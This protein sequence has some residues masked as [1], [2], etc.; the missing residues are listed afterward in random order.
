MTLG[1]GLIPQ[2]Q[3]ALGNDITLA[4]QDSVPNANIDDYWLNTNAR[5]NGFNLSFKYFDEQTSQ[6][7]PQKYTVSKTA[8]IT[9]SQ[10]QVWVQ[11]FDD[12]F[13]FV[14]KVYDSVERT[15]E[16]LKAD[17]SNTPP[18]RLNKAYFVID[19][20]IVDFS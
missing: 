14:I 4:I 10:D 19:S 18:D 13:E 11:V 6:W 2:M 15:W 3:A 20:S 9:P 5:N 7:K 8:P 16:L 12:T 1:I 17:Y